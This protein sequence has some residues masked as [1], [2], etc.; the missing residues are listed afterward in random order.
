ME[1]DAMFHEYVGDEGVGNV[2]GS[3]IVSGRNEYSFF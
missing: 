3:S 1:G 2:D